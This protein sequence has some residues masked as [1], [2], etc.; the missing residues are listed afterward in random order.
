MAPLGL[1]RNMVL[2]KDPPEHSKYRKI[3]SSV[4]T[5]KAVNRLEPTVRSRV[6]SILDKVIESGRCDF[7]RDIAV[8]V[9]LGVLAGLMGLPADDVPKLYDWTQSIG[10]SQRSPGPAAASATI[11]EMMGYLQGLVE[12]QLA[13]GGDSLVTRLRQARIDGE[14]LSDDEIL[15]FFGLLVF[16]GNDTTRNTAATGMLALLR[17]PEQWQLLRLGA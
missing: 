2:Y 8:P 1:F 4:P 12:R 11:N 17:N 6:T 7:V 10:R 14:S 5:P 15:T 13:G 3:L 16:A 9:P